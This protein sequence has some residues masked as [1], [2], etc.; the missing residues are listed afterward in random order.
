[1]RKFMF[2]FG[3]PVALLAGAVTAEPLVRLHTSYYYIDGPSATVLSAQ[4]NKNGPVGTDGN[5]HPARTRWDIKWK[6][7][8]AQH[9]TTCA[10]DAVAVVIGIAQTLPK[11]RG[12]DKGPAS[13]KARWGKFIESL[14]RHEQ[15]HKQHGMQ[16]GRDIEA[17]LRA[18]EPSSNCEALESRADQAAQEIVSK[19]QKLDE[20]Y[21]RETA[22]GRTEGGTLL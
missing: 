20:A 5:R 8:P 9:G 4:L 19:Y 3:L 16:A 10:M 7:Q 22:Y 14:Q 17:A 12:E 11:W 21:D 15:V 1:M 2:V 6:L 18:V 13:L